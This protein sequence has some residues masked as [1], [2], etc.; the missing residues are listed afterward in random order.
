MY[1]SR[2]YTKQKRVNINI[3]I[4]YLLMLEDK[5]LLGVVSI[6]AMNLLTHDRKETV[7]VAH[8]SVR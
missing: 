1:H 8:H 6:F 2:L 7:T 4:G 5:L 3:D